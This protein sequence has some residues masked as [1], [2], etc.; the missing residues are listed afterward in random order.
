MCSLMISPDNKYIHIHITISVD[1]QF[2]LY[3]IVEY[4]TL[5]IHRCLLVYSRSE[6]VNHFMQTVWLHQKP[7]TNPRRSLPCISALLKM[8]RSFMVSFCQ[9]KFPNIYIMCMTLCIQS[10]LIYSLPSNST[11]VSDELVILSIQV[12][13]EFYD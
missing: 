4:Q 3:Q 1:F 5:S 12:I 9:H 7:V 2:N 6:F 13:G 11:L 8:Y 10:W